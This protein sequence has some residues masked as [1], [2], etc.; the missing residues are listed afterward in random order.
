MKPAL[1]TG[2][3]RLLALSLMR[4]AGVNLH[5]HDHQLKRAEDIPQ[6]Q[7]IA[8]KPPKYVAQILISETDGHGSGSQKAWGA[9]SGDSIGVDPESDA[10][11]SPGIR[12]QEHCQPTRR[13]GP[14]SGLEHYSATDQGAES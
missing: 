9:T 7:A 11:P 5:Q 4:F 12:I 1:V 14:F 2:L 13:L 10:T 3:E 6:Q 8:G